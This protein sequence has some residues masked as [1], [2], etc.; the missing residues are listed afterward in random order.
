MDD[1]RPHAERVEAHVHENFNKRN[2]H[3]NFNKHANF[4]KRTNF[5]KR[6]RE[7]RKKRGFSLPDKRGQL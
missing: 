1:L 6:I 5:N 2:K 7:I 3:E 4:N